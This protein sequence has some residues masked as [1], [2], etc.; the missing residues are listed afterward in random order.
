MPLAVIVGLTVAVVIALIGAAGYL[1]ERSASAHEP[2][3]AERQ[4]PRS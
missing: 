3:V 4:P 2:G 1:I